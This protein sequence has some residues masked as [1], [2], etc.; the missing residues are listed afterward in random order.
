[1]GW[2]IMLLNLRVPTMISPSFNY[3]EVRLNEATIVV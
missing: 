2:T 1:M 3:L